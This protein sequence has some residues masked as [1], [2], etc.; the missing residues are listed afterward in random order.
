[1][2]G[3]INWLEIPVADMNRAIRF[4]EQVF[5]TSLKREAMQQVDMAVFGEME[6]GGALVAGESYRPS[7]DGCVPYLH[8]PGL[9]GLLARVQAAGGKTVFGPL[10]LPGDIGHI[11]HIIDSEGNRIGLHQPLAA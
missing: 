8:A 6:P 1:M 11:A 5:Q 9:A 10:Q 4:Y 2:S 3:L 7:A